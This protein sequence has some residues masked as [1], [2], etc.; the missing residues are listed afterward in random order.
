[1]SNLFTFKI[2]INFI[3]WW[4][5]YTFF[6]SFCMP[7]TK[8]WKWP[9][10]QSLSILVFY[11]YVCT[12]NIYWFRVLK[13]TMGPVLGSFSIWYNLQFLWFQLVFFNLIEPPP[14]SSETIPHNFKRHPPSLQTKFW[15]RCP[16]ENKRV[17]G[18]SYQH[19]PK[20]KIV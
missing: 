13:I 8:K 17:P 20:L 6:F 11:L 3:S 10:D 14:S 4:L 9:C 15:I 16:L 12:M 1:M 2:I 7:F 19:I 18:S 5:S